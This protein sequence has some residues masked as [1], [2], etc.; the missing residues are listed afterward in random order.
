MST[1]LRLYLGWYQYRYHFHDDT[2]RTMLGDREKSRPPLIQVLH[3]WAM[4]AQEHDLNWIF[5]HLSWPHCVYTLPSCVDNI[6][7]VQPNREA[8]QL[9]RRFPFFEGKVELQNEGC[10]DKILPKLPSRIH[11]VSLHNWSTKY[12]LTSSG[13]AYLTHIRTLDLIYIGS[14]A[15]TAFQHLANIQDLRIANEQTRPGMFQY[16]THLRALTL[17]KDASIPQLSHHDFMHLSGLTFLDVF[18]HPSLTEGLFERDYFPCLRSL[19]IDGCR[20]LRDTSF[21]Y[22]SSLTRLSLRGCLNS[23]VTDAAFMHMTQLRTLEMHLFP[24]NN[25]TPEAFTF[26]SQLRYLSCTI[27]RSKNTRQ[28]FDGLPQLQSL[29]IRFDGEAPT[30][31]I[32][33]GISNL[34]HLT[35]ILPSHNGFATSSDFLKPLPHLETLSVRRVSPLWTGDIFTYLT[36]LT[37]LTIRGWPSA[38]TSLATGFPYLQRL[39]VLQIIGPM[40][41]LDQPSEPPFDD[42]VLCQLPESLRELYAVGCYHLTSRGFGHL[43]QL[44]RLTVSP[45]MGLFDRIGD[46]PHLKRIDHF[47]NQMQEARKRY[48]QATKELHEM[49]SE[50]ETHISSLDQAANFGI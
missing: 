38:N 42:D 47:G 37:R 3:Y 49:L 21:G 41:L 24:E 16:L 40:T 44:S 17:K 5:R 28:L 32:F 36:K 6:E 48:E 26:L 30:E 11:E 31:D 12:A 35:A 8:D 27:P 13:M 29:Y 9:S 15:S 50:R 14:K 7:P 25:L 45:V 33:Q 39:R 20:E 4:V 18:G 2:P 1:L 10:Q 19:T 22:L 23:N 46:L 34:R 43:T